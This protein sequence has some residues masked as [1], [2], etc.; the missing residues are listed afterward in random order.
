MSAATDGSRRAAVLASPALLLA[1]QA[2]LLAGCL[3]RGPGIGMVLIYQ[4]T[5]PAAVTGL[6]FD[7]IRILGGRET[8]LYIGPAGSKHEAR[9]L[10][11]ASDPVPAVIRARWR[12]EA[13]EPVDEAAQQ[14]LPDAR[15]PWRD[16]QDSAALR[17]AITPDALALLRRE[18]DRHRLRL[19]MV[20]D[21]ER[22]LLR[23]QL[24]LTST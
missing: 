17:A 16:A 19:V 7:E 11:A 4:S 13:I 1:P 18:P 5:T 9:Q 24:T 2:L 20:F 3:R 23:W 6:W 15:L 21:R 8:S 14:G 10:P 12:Y 22:L